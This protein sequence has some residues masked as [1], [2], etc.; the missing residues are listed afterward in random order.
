MTIEKIIIGI[1]FV[2]LGFLFNFYNKN[3]AKGAFEFYKKL[4]TE[5]NLKVM[6]RAFGII[7]IIFGLI[8]IFTK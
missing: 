8:L 6:L 1:V 4:Y 5:K 7:F 2:C 3:V